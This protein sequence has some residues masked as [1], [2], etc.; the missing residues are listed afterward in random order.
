MTY[1][2]GLNEDKMARYFR[3]NRQ[4]V[5]LEYFQSKLS[6]GWLIFLVV[7]AEVVAVSVGMMIWKWV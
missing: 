4:G 2:T 1:F 3:V 5:M 6:K 7:T